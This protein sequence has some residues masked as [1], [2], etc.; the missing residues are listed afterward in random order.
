MA[1]METKAHL[2]LLVARGL[3]TSNETAEG[4]IMFT[5]TGSAAVVDVTAPDPQRG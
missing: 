3:L 5:R 1:A 2:E 4:V